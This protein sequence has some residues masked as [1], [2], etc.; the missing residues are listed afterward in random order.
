[1]VGVVGETG[2]AGL[3]LRLICLFSWLRSRCFPNS[4]LVV[5]KQALFAFKRSLLLMSKKP[6]LECK[7]ALFLKR[8]KVEGRE[9]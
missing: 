2:V 5:L 4:F 8:R 1:M 6:C 3:R 7:E 9:K